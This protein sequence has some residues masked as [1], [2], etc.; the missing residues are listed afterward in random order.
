MQAC[1]IKVKTT[2][3]TEFQF[4][5]YIGAKMKLNDIVLHVTIS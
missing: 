1:L 3:Q 4:V 2:V 5:A